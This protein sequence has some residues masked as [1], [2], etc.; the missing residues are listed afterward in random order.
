MSAINEELVKSFLKT[1]HVLL[2][3]LEKNIRQYQLSSSEFAVLDFLYQNG[4]QPI[5]QIAE[6]I[7]VT[8]GTI[9]YVL[10][11][12]L[13]KGYLIRKRCPKDKRIFY[14]D[15]TPQ[16]H[17]F[18]AQIHTEYIRFLDDLFCEY[19]EDKKKSLL[20]ALHELYEQIQKQSKN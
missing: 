5:Q 6:M 15:L 2:N 9:T 1:Q 10:D 17:N 16:G 19:T 3:K 8:S 11:K 7:S 13:K 18:I 4:R 20:T 14:A 12:L